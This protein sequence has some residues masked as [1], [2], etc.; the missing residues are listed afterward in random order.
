MWGV[1]AT[2]LAVLSK[3][4]PHFS[5]FCRFIL[6]LCVFP[7]SH[8]KGVCSLVRSDFCLIFGN[9]L[10]TSCGSD[11]VSP[12]SDTAQPKV[13]GTKQDT[14]CS[15]LSE[16]AMWGLERLRSNLLLSFK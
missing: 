8:P 2:G 3:P 13:T 15:H 9:T 4:P 7:G 1:V 12:C 16:Q 6:D 10:N 11:V 14:V 5:W